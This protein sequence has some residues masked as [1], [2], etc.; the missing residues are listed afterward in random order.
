MS[1]DAVTDDDVASV[2]AST[3]TPAP[4]VVVTSSVALRL[5]VGVVVGGVCVWI[6]ITSILHG[7]QSDAVGVVVA[8]AGWLAYLRLF[9]QRLEFRADGITYRGAILE[10][11]FPR[12]SVDRVSVQ[13]GGR[14]ARLD[15]ADGVPFRAQVLDWIW[16]ARAST[17]RH[18]VAARV[19][20]IPGR[21]F[22]V[23]ESAVPDPGRWRFPDVTSGE[24]TL[25][26]PSHAFAPL[27]LVETAWIV[28]T[29]VATLFLAVLG[30]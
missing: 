15:L 21:S 17:T 2:P 26:R 6:G 27:R 16:S 18:E 1:D 23:S 13:R 20:E 4:N 28:I 5:V 9:A 19:R 25:A 22:E 24:L 3:R 29:V 12:R 14:S 8:G 30:S 11:S 7:E 10:Y